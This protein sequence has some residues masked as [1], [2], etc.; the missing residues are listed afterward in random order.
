[1]KP[2]PLHILRPLLLLLLLFSYLGNLCHA[3]TQGSV[4]PT[5]SG[6]I[7]I[8]YSQGINVLI[9]G[10]DDLSLGTWSGT[11]PMEANDDLCIG[12]SGVGFFGTGLYRIRASGDGEPAFP[13]AFTLS[14]GVNRIH[15][16]VYFNDEAGLT[17]RTPLSPGVIISNQS[18]FG[19][20][21]IFNM[22]FGCTVQNANIS[23]EVPETELS[24]AAGTYTGT[25]TLLL[26]P[27]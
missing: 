1:M 5:S 2:V 3:A 25:L 26:I 22:L 27:E 24:G 19:L 4:G 16:D 10:L 17:G 23:I 7:D 8:V 11:G 9:A 15:Y 20:F 14:N 13:A 21:F 12:R 18:S 6:S